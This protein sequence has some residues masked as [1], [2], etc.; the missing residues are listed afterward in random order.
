MLIL[1][2]A[3]ASGK[4]EI[5]KLLIKKHG[6]EKLVTTTTRPMRDGEVNGID[7]HFV[8]PDEFYAKKDND[9]FFETVIYNENYYGTPKDC[10]KNNVLI[11]DPIGAN[12]I[13]MNSTGHMFIVLTTSEEVRRERMLA[14]GDKLEA[15]ESRLEHDRAHFE[16][17]KMNHFDHSIETD[18]KTLDELA[19]L[20]AELYK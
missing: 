17:N 7:Y 19:D 15:I 10:K 16:L 11:V 18:N 14:R 6:F 4:T 13:F 1:I 9:E 3:S 20:I 2:G 8:T 12:N 5:A